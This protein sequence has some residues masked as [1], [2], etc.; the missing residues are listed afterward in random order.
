VTIRA[1]AHRQAAAGRVKVRIEVSDTGPGIGEADRERIFSPFVRLGDRP[2]INSGTGLGLAI[3]KQHVELMGGEI[4]VAGEPGRGSVFHFEIPVKE[5]S[6]EAMP[7]ASRRGRVTGL[8][9][10]QPHY[11]LLIAEDNLMNRLLLRKLLEPLGF[12][13]REAANGEEAVA[14]FEKW[15]PHLIWM[16]IRMPVLD[17]LEATR[18][19]KASDL[20]PNTKIVA[21]TAHALEEERSEILASECDDFIRKPYQQHEIIDALRKHLGVRFLYEEA[22]S[23]A[24]G[25]ALLNA[26]DLADL[27]SAWLHDL[28]QALVRLD[29]GAVNLAIEGI[30]AH[31]P[32]QAD[33]LGATARDLQFGRML[34]VIRAACSGTEPDGRDA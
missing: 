5:L 3:S 10:G 12:D 20:G 25:D 2:P 16:D 30:R 28:E 34:R 4:G 14:V 27:P 21:V 9:E 13:L 33:A 15:R 24:A 17:G 7:A 8:A 18:R 31:H 19:I 26:G 32:S 11:R 1:L 22:P 29:I 23:P 6:P